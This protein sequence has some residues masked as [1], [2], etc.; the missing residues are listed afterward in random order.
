M[1]E[2]AVLHGL[3]AKRGSLVHIRL[4]LLS[5]ADA[6]FPTRK[7]DT[8]LP[9]VSSSE[10][11]SSGAH[12]A[13]VDCAVSARRFSPTRGPFH[14]HST[15]TTRV[16]S[17]EELMGVALEALQ[18]S[19]LLHATGPSGQ[20]C[21]LSGYKY[22]PS[23]PHRLTNTTLAASTPSEIPPMAPFLRNYRPKKPMSRPAPVFAHKTKHIIRKQLTLVSLFQLKLPR[24]SLDLRSYRSVV[25]IFAPA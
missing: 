1:E 14:M 8:T 19:H 22:R 12:T 4:Q 3:H 23:S 9:H 7:A 11:P 20:G 16:A 13:I 17:R 25:V 6:L 18:L 2:E 15:R 10:G 21:G 24:L 5:C